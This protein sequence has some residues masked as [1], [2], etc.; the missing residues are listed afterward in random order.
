MA[1]RHYGLRAS[2][3][4]QQHTGPVHAE[5][6]TGAVFIGIIIAIIIVLGVGMY[7]MNKAVN[8]LA[9]TTTSDPPTELVVHRHPVGWR[10]RNLWSQVLE[11]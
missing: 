4:T 6:W 2:K 1:H 10:G 5:T 11:S 8:D 7:V 9:H 3:R